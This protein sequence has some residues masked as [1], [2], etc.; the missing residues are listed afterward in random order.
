[1][2]VRFNKYTSNT[3]VYKQYDGFRFISISLHI[4]IESYIL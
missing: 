4:E 3:Y 2:N 1:M